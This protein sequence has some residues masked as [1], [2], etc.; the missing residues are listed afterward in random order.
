MLEGR[1]RS[2][3]EDSLATA[4]GGPIR[5]ALT[6]DSAL[7]PP[8]GEAGS[9]AGLPTSPSLQGDEATQGYDGMSTKSPVDEALQ[10]FPPRGG[11]GG[12]TV[13]TAQEARNLRNRLCD[14]VRDQRARGERPDDAAE[15]GC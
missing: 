3:L 7:V 8:T 15:I 4:L 10:G 14:Y 11:C 6:V 13:G 1:L 5:L 2:R 9:D 12:G